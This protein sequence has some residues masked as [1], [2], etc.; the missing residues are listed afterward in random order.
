MNHSYTTGEEKML[1]ERWHECTTKEL[2]DEIGVSERALTMHASRMGL[3]RVSHQCGVPWRDD[4]VKAVRLLACMGLSDVEIADAL[5]RGVRGVRRLRL[6]M[7][8]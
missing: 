2:A 1:R 7:G 8:V 5:N 6:K 3:K 4:E